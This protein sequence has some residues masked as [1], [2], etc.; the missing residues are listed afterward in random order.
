MASLFH[1]KLKPSKKYAA[2]AVLCCSLCSV[3]SAIAFAANSKNKGAQTQNPSKEAKISEAP[4]QDPR[5]GLNARWRID[6]PDLVFAEAKKSQKNVLFYWGAVWCPP[7]NELKREVFNKPSFDEVS[8]NFLL[9]YLDGDVPAAQLWADKLKVSGYPSVLVFNP[10]G[11]ELIRF[12]E[13]VP[14]KTLAQSLG[15]IDANTLPLPLL[16]DKLRSGKATPQEWALVA[17]AGWDDSMIDVGVPE[18][19]LLPLVWELSQKAPAGSDVANAIFAAQVLQRAADESKNKSTPYEKL[20]SQVMESSKNLF[21]KIVLNDETTLACKDFLLGDIEQTVLWLS[22]QKDSTWRKDLKRKWLAA[23]SALGGMKS[24]SVDTK[25][26]SLHPKAVFEVID[27]PENKRDKN[28]YGETL[29]SEIVNAVRQADMETTHLDTQNPAAGLAR[30]AVIAGAA[31]FMAEIGEIEKARILLNKELRS[32]STPWYIQ[33]TLASVE[34]KAGNKE[35]AIEWMRQAALSAK[36]SSTQLQWSASYIGELAS[37]LKSTSAELAQDNPLFL[38]KVS[39]LKEALRNY[40][41]MAFEASD[42]FSGRNF[43]RQKKMSTQMLALGNAKLNADMVSE[44]SKKC[45]GLSSKFKGNSAILLDG[46][47]K[48]QSH[49]TSHFAQYLTLASGKE[50]KQ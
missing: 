41:G 24:V 10:N 21:E 19:Q 40:Y 15:T 29:R 50:K 39:T 42:G 46:M 11:Q 38:A 6:D 8:Q 23:G 26:W 14:L 48:A 18:E 9:V 36:G 3:L 44:Y 7:C 2:F 43:G 47:N 28:A 22:P 25:L 16:V 45:E 27:I 4:H 31:S 5:H 35:V 30:K 34:K 37:Q 32:V 17:S 1:L 13:S 49:C 20:L 33:S 12:V